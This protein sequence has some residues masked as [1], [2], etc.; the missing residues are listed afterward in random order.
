MPDWTLDSLNRPQDE[1]A[2]RD[3]LH[4]CCA[5]QSWIS[6][7]DGG[8][9]YRDEDA[10]GDA[11]D[12]ATAAL[13]AAGLAEA[14]DGHPRIGQ[15]APSHSGAWSRQEQAGVSAADGSVRADLAAA[16]AAYEERFGQLYLVCATGRSA[17]QLLALCRARLTNDPRTEHAV[18]LD[19]LA[20][21]N[22]LR[23][24]KLLH[25]ESS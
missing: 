25:A 10:L 24:G 3:A 1:D 6:S 11:S 4:R 9:P 20:K 21:I 13:D 18:V 14:L 2:L 22:R 15:Q 12:E 23:L 8:R 17:D 7:I 5:A 16:N 19:E